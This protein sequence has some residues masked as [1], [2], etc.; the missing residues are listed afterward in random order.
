MSLTRLEI[1][2]LLGCTL[3]T[4]GAFWF[5]RS[6]V[7][8]RS[9]AV[10]PIGLARRLSQPLQNGK[11]EGLV[12]QA[13]DYQ[14]PP[15]HDQELSNRLYRTMHPDV[16]WR[17]LQFPLP[18]HSRAKELARFVLA[19]QPGEFKRA[20]DAL[21]SADVNRNTDLRKILGEE[22]FARLSKNIANDRDRL[23][24]RLRLLKAMPFTS[25]P[26]YLFFLPNGRSIVVPSIQQVDR[27]LDLS[28]HR[29]IMQ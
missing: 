17:I 15:C 24:G 12:V 26:S 14:C 16:E 7:L 23:N 22:S 20:H 9:H 13:L 21:M 2:G 5:Y 10:I 11:G 3:L 28:P 1:F 6:H 27:L 25:T 4:S 19:S 18:I 29:E 8:D